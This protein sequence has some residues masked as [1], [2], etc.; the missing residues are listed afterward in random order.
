MNKEEIIERIEK[1]AKK[2]FEKANGCHDWSHVERVRSL[3][4]N[5]GKKEGADLF[6]LELA[7]ILHDVGRYEEMQKSKESNGSVKYCHAKEGARISR[8]LLKNCDIK[9]RDFKNIV[10]CVESHRHRNSLNPETIEAKVLYDADKIDG[11]GAIGIG[12]IFL[13]AGSHGSRNL[14]TGNEKRLAKE[15]GDYSYTKDDSAP[16]EYEI[17]LKYTL[18][19]MLTDTGK[20][21]AKKR[22]VLMDNFF[23]SFWE[24]IEGKR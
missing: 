20:K 4:L 18:K 22:L 23:E 24:E 21:I 14:Y 17:K 13:F 12:R 5:I 19:K 11:I 1:D 8:E 6:I 9:E 16:L 2:Y 15:G 3:A 7:S 10:H